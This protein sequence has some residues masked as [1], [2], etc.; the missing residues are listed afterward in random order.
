[1]VKYKI[2][3]DLEGTNLAHV[4]QIGRGLNKRIMEKAIKENF[5]ING[6]FVVSGSDTKVRNV[7][8]MRLK[9]EET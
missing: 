2:I 6:E 1:M 3:F 8:I 9:N 4:I 7:L 5:D